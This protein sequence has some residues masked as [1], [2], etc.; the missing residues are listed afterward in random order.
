MEVVVYRELVLLVALVVVMI[1]L[2][3]GP[4]LSQ[5]MNHMFFPGEN[6]KL[7]N[8]CHRV[9]L[10]DKMCNIVFHPLKPSSTC[11][12]NSNVDAHKPDICDTMVYQHNLM[13]LGLLIVN[14]SRTSNMCPWYVRLHDTGYTKGHHDLPCPC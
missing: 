13:G 12:H 7:D 8:F 9:P 14:N 11:I 4:H 6:H 5:N 3:G 2:S 10:I 1:V